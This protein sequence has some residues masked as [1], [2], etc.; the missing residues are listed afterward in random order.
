MIVQPRESSFVREPYW[1]L[2]LIVAGTTVAS[3]W[4]IGA[5]VLAILGLCTVMPQYMLPVAVLVLGLGF[6]N[7]A[8][9]N[10]AWERMFRFT[11]AQATQ[12]WRAYFGGTIAVMAAG[13]VAIVLGILNLV[14]LADLRV[15]AVAAIAMGLG[16][17]MHSGIVRSISRFTH[18]TAFGGE[19]VRPNGPF[20]FNALSVAPVRDALVGIAGVVL[21]ILALL[22]IATLTLGLVAMVAMGAA[23]AFTAS[24]VCGATL[25]ALNRHCAMRAG[26]KALAM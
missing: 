1:F 19:A 15:A 3:M 17:F 23:L 18:E 4:A 14:F 22:Q 16:M 26:G 20:A 21:G 6:V 12:D 2:S 13:I 10:I 8:S 25:T 24:T 9:I 11:N 5:A 7:L